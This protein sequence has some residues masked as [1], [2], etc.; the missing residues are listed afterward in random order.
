MTLT[1]TRREPAALAPAL[2][3]IRSIPTL[4]RDKLGTS[5]IAPISEVDTLTLITRIESTTDA[6]MLWNIHLELDRREIAPIFRYPKNILTPQ[7][8]FITWLA[9]VY[10]LTRRNP[11]RKAGYKAWNAM[12]RPISEC[13]HESAL[14]V[15][16]FAYQRGYGATYYTKGFELSDADRRGLMTIKSTRQI[17]K[18]RA[19]K[20]STGMHAA[21]R[22]YAIVNVKKSGDRDPV[23]I[24][25]R[26]YF[27]WK[28][29]ILADRS[30]TVAARVYYR[31]YGEEITRQGLGKQMTAVDAAWRKFGNDI[32]S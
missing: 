28:T 26:R 24:A 7:A 27:L 5:K 10:Y 11:S 19:L 25:R 13:W 18:L 23:D 21:L 30:E 3:C 16:S 4:E 12:F 8:E 20:H 14:R 17:A 1:L 32:L 31:I 6:L 2:E 15:F 29:F 22:K 9:D